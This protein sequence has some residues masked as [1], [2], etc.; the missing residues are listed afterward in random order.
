M[1]FAYTVESFE[2]A[3]NPVGIEVLPTGMPVNGIVTGSCHSW[4]PSTFILV[5]GGAG[6]VAKDAMEQGKG[7]LEKGKD[8]VGGTL[9]KLLGISTLQ[10]GKRFDTLQHRY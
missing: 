4:D 9:N 3:S 1:K 10:N 6:G 7:A 2:M 8:A 5:I